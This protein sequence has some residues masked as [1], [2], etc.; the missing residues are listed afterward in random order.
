[1]VAVGVRSHTQGE[2][3]LKRFLIHFYNRNTRLKPGENETGQRLMPVTNRSTRLKP[4]EN[5][6]G[7][8]T[9]AG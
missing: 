3:P 4:G 6:T 1:M 9:Q 5:E 8:K 2:K 7:P